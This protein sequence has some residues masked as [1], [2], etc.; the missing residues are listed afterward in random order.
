MALDFVFLWLTGPGGLLLIGMGIIVPFLFWPLLLG[1]HYRA[2]GLMPLTVA[3]VSALTGLIVMSLV[4]GYV[5]FSARVEKGIL[6]ETQRWSVVPG[7]TL[8]ST[9]LSLIIVLPAL[10][11]IAVPF[12][13]WLLRNRRLHLK[14]IIIS[15]TVFSVG[16]ATL[17]W[18]FP[19]NDWHR[20][21]RLESFGDWLADTF[22]HLTFIG[23]PFLASL[24]IFAPRRKD[25]EALKGAVP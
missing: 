21:H 23:A 1:T 15:L 2:I 7:W 14:S 13:A 22:I 10:G 20:T 6:S 19:A 25:E 17:F 12:G 8:Y 4:Y 11:L 9:F 24:S 3:Y 5:E 16:L 18:A